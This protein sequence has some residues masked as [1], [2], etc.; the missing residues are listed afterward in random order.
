[1]EALSGLN[2]TAQCVMSASRRRSST[3]RRNCNQSDGSNDL[4]VRTS[5]RKNLRISE[6]L[7]WNYAAHF[8][9]NHFLLWLALPSSKSAAFCHSQFKG[10]L[11]LKSQF[12]R[13]SME[14]QLFFGFRLAQSCWPPSVQESLCRLEGAVRVKRHVASLRRIA[15]R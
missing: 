9:K 7:V 14:R 8:R 2:P 3:F 1:M 10:R 11:C 5:E 13:R 4:R 12:Q 15:H 6:A